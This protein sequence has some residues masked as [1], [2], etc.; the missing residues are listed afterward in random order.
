[1]RRA[2]QSRTRATPEVGRARPTVAHPSALGGLAQAGEQDDPTFAHYP[3]ECSR[4]GQGPEARV[5][6]GSLADAACDERSR[7][8]S[9]T[10]ASR[11]PASYAC[12]S[13]RARRFCHRRQRGCEEVTAPKGTML[14]FPRRARSCGR[15]PHSSCVFGAKPSMAPFIWWNFVSSTPSARRSGARWRRTQVALIPGREGFCRYDGPHFR[16]PE[17][18]DTAPDARGGHLRLAKHGSR[19]EAICRRACSRRH[20]GKASS[21]CALV[22]TA[23][24]ADHSTPPR[25]ERA[26]HPRAGL[27]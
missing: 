6:V 13:P 5:L 23:I 18:R 14:A 26:A 24:R 16:S 27:R 3:A 20:I 9:P 12:R 7:R 11:E 19:V 2:R 25:T 8:S 1:M 21:G 15:R 17:L 22:R 4:A 10:S